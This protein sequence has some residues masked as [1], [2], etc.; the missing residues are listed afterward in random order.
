MRYLLHIHQQGGSWHCQIFKR[1]VSTFSEQPLT[2]K[3]QG[4]QACLRGENFSSR[5][6]WPTSTRCH[7]H[8]QGLRP[9]CHNALK[10]AQKQTH[11]GRWFHV[12]CSFPE[13]LRLI[14]RPRSG[15]FIKQLY[16]SIQ[17]LLEIILPHE[18]TFSAAQQFPLGKHL[19]F[20]TSYN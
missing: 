11:L 20:L 15:M 10:R 8:G 2:F 16:L 13:Q 14:L 9:A 4:H 6:H 12:G 17:I 19:L 3:G 1:S 18:N 7:I 5:F